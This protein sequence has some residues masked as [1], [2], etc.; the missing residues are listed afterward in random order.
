[1]GFLVITTNFLIPVL[2][3]VHVDVGISVSTVL[4]RTL[5]HALKSEYK[6]TLMYKGITLEEKRKKRLEITARKYALAVDLFQ[7]LFEV[8][9]K[10]IYLLLL[11][12]KLQVFPAVVRE[13]NSTDQSKLQNYG[14][15]KKLQLRVSCTKAI[16]R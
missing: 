9:F 8:F 5:Q 2:C 3:V 15:I 12:L 11:L 6:G 4:M 7:R 13:L 10:F 14:S 16:I 1:M